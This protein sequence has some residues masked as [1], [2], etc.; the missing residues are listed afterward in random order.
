MLADIVN[1]FTSLKYKYSSLLRAEAWS[2]GDN[3]NS[4]LQGK[5]DKAAVKVSYAKAE[6]QFLYVNQYLP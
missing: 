1:Y 2:W 4:E 6:K 5:K 3:I